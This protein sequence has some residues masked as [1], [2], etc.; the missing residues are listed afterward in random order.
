MFI[1]PI[2][3]DEDVHSSFG[4]SRCSTGPSGDARES[5]AFLLIHHLQTDICEHHAIA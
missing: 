3:A 1:A 2:Y 5:S 4:K